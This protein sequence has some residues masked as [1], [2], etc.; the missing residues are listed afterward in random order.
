MS[1]W[2]GKAFLTAEDVAQIFT[3]EAQARADAKA[4]GGKAPPVKPFGAKMVRNCV[5]ASRPA[6]TSPAG[7]QDTGN[8]ATKSAGRYL[9]EPIPMPDEETEGHGKSMTWSPNPP[10]PAGMN[11][12]VRSLRKWYSDDR[13]GSGAGGGPKPKAEGRGRK[14]RKK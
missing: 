8:R 3:E 4:D 6:K 13:P 11:D 7:G 5:Y 9:D 2:E 1:W 10:T 14:R 12:L